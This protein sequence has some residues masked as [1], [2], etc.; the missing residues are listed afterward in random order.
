MSGGTFD[1]IQYRLNDAVEEIKKRLNLNRKT[2]LE[3]WNS[4]SEEQRSSLRDY[5]RPWTMNSY[6]YWVENEAQKKAYESIPR[7][8]LTCSNLKNGRNFNGLSKEDLDKWNKVYRK[9]LQQIIDDHNSSFIGD[10]YSDETVSKIKEM[11]HTIR[12]AEI[13]LQRIDWLF[14]GDDGED[15]FMER[16]AEEVAELER[17]KNKDE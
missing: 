11:I 7:S 4:L 9:T 1:Y 3:N 13:Y 5:E 2:I 10:D 16:T 8:K 14:A 12:L 17:E 15:N 6:P